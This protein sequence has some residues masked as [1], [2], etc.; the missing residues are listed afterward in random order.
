MIEVLQSVK[1]PLMIP[2]HFFSAYTLQRFLNRARELTWEVE[3]AVVPATVISKT[4]LP[5]KP[6]VLA[7]PGH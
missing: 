1:A 2:M 5:T 7:L 3:T 4:S 6:K